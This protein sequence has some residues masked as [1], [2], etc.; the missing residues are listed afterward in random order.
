[1]ADGQIKIQPYDLDAEKAVLGSIIIDND[2]AEVVFSV[3]N[4]GDFRASAHSVIF[5]AMIEMH[6]SELAIDTLTLVNYLTEKQFP[7]C[8]CCSSVK[9]FTCIWYV[10]YAH[11]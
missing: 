10:I 4:P 5:K 11:Q 2:C 7:N 6:R 3:L 9:C 1:M 8:N